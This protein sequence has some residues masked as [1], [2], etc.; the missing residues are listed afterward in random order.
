M[1]RRKAIA[2]SSATIASLL[3]E[4]C[5]FK[6]KSKKVNN[7]SQINNINRNRVLYF[8]DLNDQDLKTLQESLIKE[9][10]KEIYKLSTF[11]KINYKDDVPIGIKVTPIFKDPLPLSLKKIKLEYIKAYNTQNYI[12]QEGKRNFDAYVY[13]RYINANIEILSNG[14]YK[15]TLSPNDESKFFPKK[16][17]SNYIEISK[18]RPMEKNEFNKYGSELKDNYKFLSNLAQE[19][20]NSI[21]H[22][23]M[24]VKSNTE[25]KIDK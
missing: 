17:Y 5:S 19:D 18:S 3:I 7:I 24:D 13:E 25:I 2:I 21:V 4:G 12:N 14:V 16:V 11:N 10:S 6:N 23:N 22:F 20:Y 1:T 9:I 15:I 8:Y